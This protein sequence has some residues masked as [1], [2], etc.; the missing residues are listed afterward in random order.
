MGGGGRAGREGGKDAPTYD[1]RPL[2]LVRGSEMPVLA[3]MAWAAPRATPYRVT[4]LS[5]LCVMS[6]SVFLFLFRLLP[7]LQGPGPT[8]ATTGRGG[9]G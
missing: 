6:F 9:R 7:G 1:F 4:L 3:L 8:A 2:W 5:A